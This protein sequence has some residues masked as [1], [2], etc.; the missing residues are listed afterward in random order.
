MIQNGEVRDHACWHCGYPFTFNATSCDGYNE[1][2]VC[3]G[4]DL[5]KG[6]ILSEHYHPI[7]NPVNIHL[8]FATGPSSKEKN[9]GLFLPKRRIIFVSFR[10]KLLFFLIAEKEEQVQVPRF[11]RF[12]LNYGAK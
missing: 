8:A 9:S 10:N 5:G 2:I 12:I 3:K 7:M 4:K 6:K 11:S 1:K